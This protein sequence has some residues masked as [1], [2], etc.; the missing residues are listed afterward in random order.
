MKLTTRINKAVLIYA[1]LFMDF[2]QS[3]QPFGGVSIHAMASNEVATR[4]TTETSFARHFGML[5]VM[6]M[7]TL[8]KSPCGG[9][10]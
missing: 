5:L 4:L 1:V 2:K 8:R 9:D 7:T 6:N 3:Q 10:P